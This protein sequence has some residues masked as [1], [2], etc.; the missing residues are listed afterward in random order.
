MEI[1][2]GTYPHWDAVLFYAKH[3][4]IVKVVKKRLEGDFS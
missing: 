1:I 2:I 4:K 3:I